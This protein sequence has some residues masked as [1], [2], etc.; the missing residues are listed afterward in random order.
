MIGSYQ[1]F[2][3]D[4]KFCDLFIIVDAFRMLLPFFFNLHKY[5]AVRTSFNVD[6]FLV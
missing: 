4:S 3:A 1:H 2:I 5:I 6:D